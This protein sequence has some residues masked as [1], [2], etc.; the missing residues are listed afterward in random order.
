MSLRGWNL[1]QV[2]LCSLTCIRVIQEPSIAITTDKIG[3][4]RMY[5]STRVQG[6]QQK[7]TLNGGL[8][9]LN[10]TSYKE[11]KYRR[12][13]WMRRKRKRATYT[14]WWRCYPGL[15]EVSTTQTSTQL[16]V[17]LLFFF[18]EENEWV[19]AKLRDGSSRGERGTRKFPCQATTVVERSK[20]IQSSLH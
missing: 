1:P 7:C 2:L 3:K 20:Y 13:F 6:K 11:W 18:R 10:W 14:Y 4:S 15:R 17:V 16:P 12:Y 19:S 5:T 9:Q 8:S